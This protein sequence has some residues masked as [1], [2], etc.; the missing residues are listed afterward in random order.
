MSTPETDNQTFD[1]EMVYRD[2]EGN[3]ERTD[4][5]DGS[6]EYVIAEHARNLER[7]RNELL[8]ACIAAEAKLRAYV[9]SLDLEFGGCRTD[10]ELEAANQWPAEAHKCRA[11]ITKAKEAA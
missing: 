8:E 2:Y 10:N 9:V 7:Q 5:P 3:M 4:Y 1:I 6:G 11:A